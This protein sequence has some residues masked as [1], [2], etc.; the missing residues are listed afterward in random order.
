MFCKICFAWDLKVMQETGTC[1]PFRAGNQ[2]RLADIDVFKDFKSVK[3][4]HLLAEDLQ[5]V[6]EFHRKAIY[7]ILSLPHGMLW[8][9][10]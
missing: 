4:S 2:K 10:G 3:I 7:L 8:L 9:M 5:V 6:S 1:V